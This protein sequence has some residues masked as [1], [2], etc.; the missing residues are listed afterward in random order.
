MYGTF[1][2]QAKTMKHEGFGHLTTRLSTIKTSKNLGWSG[3]GSQR[4]CRL[5]VSSRPW[6]ATGKYWHPTSAVKPTQ[7]F[8]YGQPSIPTTK[9]IK[10]QLQHTKNCW[11]ITTNICKTKHIIAFPH[12]QTFSTREQ[13]NAETPSLPPPP[14]FLGQ[15]SRGLI[16]FIVRLHMY[17]FPT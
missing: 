11:H 1:G 15:G 3:S 5:S 7:R 2:P 4:S 9:R 17:I 6:S 13:K 10:L 8:C 16:D 12:I 14:F